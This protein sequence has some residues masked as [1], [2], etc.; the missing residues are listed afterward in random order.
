MR[1]GAAPAVW[2]AAAQRWAAEAYARVG[3]GAT[4]RCLEAASPW[5]FRRAAAPRS[6]N[7]FARNLRR[8]AGL[9][10]C[11]VSASFESY[12][13]CASGVG[14]CAKL[15]RATSRAAAPR[16]RPHSAYRRGS[17]AAV[18][19][20][21]AAAASVAS[22]ASSSAASGASSTSS[23]AS[24][25]DA[26]AARW[27]V[28]DALLALPAAATKT[29][30]TGFAA[31]NAAAFGNVRSGAVRVPWGRGVG[32]EQR[33]RYGKPTARVRFVSALQLQALLLSTRCIAAR[34]WCSGTCRK[35]EGPRCETSSESRRP[36]ATGSSTG[37]LR[38]RLAAA[39]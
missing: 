4:L 19:S 20:A 25:Q 32:E 11:C 17:S 35:P 37:A 27:R 34:C 8:R 15:P 5:G 13:G 30:D 22:Y 36:L 10:T 24:L 31:C 14:R 12:I 21:V 1:G 33:F 2:C 29:G 26:V 9:F 38:F 18:T 6:R 3:S 23:V 16:P 39:P 28:R 7:S